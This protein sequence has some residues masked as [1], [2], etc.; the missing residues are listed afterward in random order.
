MNWKLSGL[1]LASAAVLAGCGSE[2]D[3]SS[4]PAS[5]YV[6]VAHLSPNAPSVD[7]CVKEG[8]GTFT[9]PVLESIGVSAG[10][11]YTGVTKYLT[12]AAGQYPVR[13]VAP[14][15][16]DCSASLAGLPDYTLPNLAGGTYA[17]AA[18]IGLVGGT[19][20]FTVKPFVDENTVATGKG[21]VRFIHASPGT[22]PVDVGVG[23]GASFAAVFSN[24]AF[25]DIGAGAGIDANGY[26]AT[27][28]LTNVTLSARVHGTTADALVVP[29]VSLAAGT[30]A[31]V[32]AIGI[33]GDATTPLRALVC[34]D[35]VAPTGNLS[36]C[37]V[38]GS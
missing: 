3:G 26:F 29:G 12:L 10:L 4:T 25:P 30:T 8:S 19:P 28:P 31:T 24:V 16:T 9:G 1:A 13:L 38:E 34:G 15:A 7:F 27:N 6:R 36:T 22:P 23:T 18:A 37:A 35:N 33:A 14:T 32:F 2:D 21:A 11:P 20:S 5:I 17:T